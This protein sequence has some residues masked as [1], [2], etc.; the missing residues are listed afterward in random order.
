MYTLDAE[1][2]DRLFHRVSCAPLVANEANE[3][4]GCSSHCFGLTRLALHARR[5]CGYYDAYSKTPEA[6]PLLYWSLHGFR[7]AR[8]VCSLELVQLK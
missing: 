5:S 7:T 6:G 3:Q 8:C 2:M 1:G 4:L